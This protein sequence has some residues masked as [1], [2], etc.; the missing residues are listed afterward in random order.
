LQVERVTSLRAFTSPTQNIYCVL[1]SDWASC[2]ALRRTWKVPPRP[3]TCDTDWG[4]DIEVVGPAP[5]TFR[6][7]S[8]AAPYDWTA[9]RQLQ[10][11]HAIRFGNMQCQSSEAAMRCDNLTTRHGFTISRDSYQLR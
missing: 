9:E 5:A 3:A 2:R 11:G 4:D 7:S 1:D 8:D 6:C 10:Y